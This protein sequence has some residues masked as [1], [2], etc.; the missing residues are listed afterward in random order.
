MKERQGSPSGDNN[1]SHQ[2]DAA[3]HR[4][5]AS[6]SSVS[7]DNGITP[8]NAIRVANS[9]LRTVCLVPVEI[10]YENKPSKVYFVSVE[11]LPGDLSERVFDI[12][13]AACE[14]LNKSHPEFFEGKVSVTTLEHA[15]F[16]VT[17]PHYDNL[18]SSDFARSKPGQAE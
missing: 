3:N 9:E 13:A 15:F 4:L 10:I 18:F 7:I 14:A 8:D 6:D 12:K 1:N 16:T 2:N 5:G 11:N 17:N